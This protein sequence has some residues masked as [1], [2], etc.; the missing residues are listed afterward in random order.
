MRSVREAMPSFSGANSLGTTV[1]A[2]DAPSGEN[3][4]VLSTSPVD[5][6]R[7]SPF[8]AMSAM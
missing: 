8:V 5:V 2:S 3:C 4:G 6:I 1:N 7:S